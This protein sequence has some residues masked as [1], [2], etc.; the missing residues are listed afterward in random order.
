MKKQAQI[1]QKYGKTFY[2]A[3]FFLDKNIKLRLFSIYAF[4][5][6][7]DDMVDNNR[8]EL[9]KHLKKNFHKKIEG[10]VGLEK[11]F[12]PSK[13]I[14]NQFILGQKSDLFHKQPKSINEL[15]IYCYRVAGI[16]GLMVCDAL[17]V[18]DKNI[19]RYAIDLGIAMQLTNISRDIKEDS[20][21]GRVYLPN[22]LVGKLKAAEVNNP[23]K[24]TYNKIKAGQN[25]LLK[26]AD[27]YYRSAEYAIPF[28]PG[29][30]SIAIRIASKLYQAI[31]K[32]ITN[33]NISYLD[34]RVYVGK[35]EKL[36]ITLAHIYTKDRICK[37]LI[38]H[39][40]KLHIA[41]KTFPGAHKIEKNI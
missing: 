32:K 35:Y 40:I 36:K 1:I 9:N 34:G 26:L 11:R 20:V 37:K 24:I 5:R 8:K 12:N 30:T 27:K 15:T 31:G 4:C 33:N 29:K 39:N 10:F 16:V 22:S 38:T 19:R 28:L 41:I 17:E 18:K 6:K 25:T 7:I 13:K 23:N 21:M 2:W 3:S 14:M